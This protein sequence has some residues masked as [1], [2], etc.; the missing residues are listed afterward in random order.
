MGIVDAVSSA[1]TKITLDKDHQVYVQSDDSSV[2]L[3]FPT[4]KRIIIIDEVI[5]SVPEA[6]GKEIKKFADGV[7]ILRSSIIPNVNG[8]LMNSTQVVE[9]M[10]AAK[11]SVFISV[12]SNE[13]TGIAYD[14]FSDP[15]AE[16]ATYISF[17]VNGI[18]TENPATAIAYLSKISLL[19][20]LAFHLGFRC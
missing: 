13:F 18:M 3:K 1:L 2:L 8:F 15:V 9:K 20:I 12:L 16:L 5:S 11:L 4:Y 14:F 7:N 19:S 10:Q 17:G 6:V